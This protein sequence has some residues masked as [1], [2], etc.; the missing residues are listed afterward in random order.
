MRAWLMVCISIPDYTTKG[1]IK[2]SGEPSHRKPQDPD[3]GLL[4]FLVAR[5]TVLSE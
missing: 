3:K 5:E 1:E 2:P 4:L